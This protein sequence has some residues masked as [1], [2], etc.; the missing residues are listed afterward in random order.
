MRDVGQCRAERSGGANRHR[1]AASARGSFR[2]RA[3]AA[4]AAFCSAFLALGLLPAFSCARVR[5]SSRG[6]QT[7]A[8]GSHS[9][10][11]LRIARPRTQRRACCFVSFGLRPA[12]RA[13]AAER[14]S[15]RQPEQTDGARVSRNATALRHTTRARGAPFFSLLDLGAMVQRTCTRERAKSV[16]L[17]RAA[18]I[19]R[20]HRDGALQARQRCSA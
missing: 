6:G 2:E 13:S 11:T 9:A 20:R 4:R 3:L 12:A 14:G 18:R 17:R 5:V 16:R 19:A 10:S 1:A 15:T 7:R 8:G